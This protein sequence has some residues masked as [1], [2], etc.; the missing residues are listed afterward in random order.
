M[1][2]ATA[3]TRISCGRTPAPS[4]R[5]TSSPS[6]EGRLTGAGAQTT[7]ARLC[8]MM[9]K[10]MVLITQDMPGLPAKGRT[11]TRNRMMPMAPMAT[12]TAGAASG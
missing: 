6:G 2:T 4:T 7:S 12:P 1:A 5:M 11:A 8:R 9:P 10:P 3:S